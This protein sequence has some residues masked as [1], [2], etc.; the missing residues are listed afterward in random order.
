[1]NKLKYR[2][3]DLTAA[4]KFNNENPISTQE[5]KDLIISSIQDKKG[6]KIVELDLTD[7]PEAPTDYFI[8]CEGESYTQVKAIS[9]NIQKTLKEEHRILPN[10]M[11]GAQTGKW[12][13]VDYF[14]VVVHVFHPETRS[15]YE[16]E[17]LW[18]DAKVENIAEDK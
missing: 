18:S 4:V 3:I 8:V 16:I 2:K 1:M 17:E 12:V 7:I 10:H 13:L 11:E 14:D 9:E 5:L 15:F 6:K